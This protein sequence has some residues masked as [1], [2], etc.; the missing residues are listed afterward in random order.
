MGSICLKKNNVVVSQIPP[1]QIEN[2]IKLKGSKPPE[3]QKIENI[4]ENIQ[5]K[6]NSEQ[7]KQTA[8]V[9]N[10]KEDT[11]GKDQKENNNKLFFSDKNN[12]KI[13]MNSNS[14]SINTIQEARRSL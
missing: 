8:N 3:N 13:E 1:N 7:N 11:E 6:D 2:K 9:D 4:N 5:P 12:I 14:N 10:K